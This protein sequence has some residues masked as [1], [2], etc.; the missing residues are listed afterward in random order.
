MTQDELKNIIESEGDY[1][2]FEYKG[3]KCRIIRVGAGVS[4]MIHLCGYILIPQG[5]KYYQEYFDNLDI[6]IHGGITYSSTNLRFQPEEGW[7][8]GFDCAHS[9]DLCYMYES[10]NY[11]HDVYRTMEFVESE[12]KSAV[13]QLKAI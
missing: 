13:D 12:L 10:E 7:W 9:G 3:Y 4:K 8:I 6:N 5:K 1:K 2:A 11:S